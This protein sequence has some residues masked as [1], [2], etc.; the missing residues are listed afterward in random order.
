[1]KIGMTSVYVK[2]PVKAYRFYTD[3]LGFTKKVFV[4]EAGLAIVVSS[5]DRSGTSLLLEP[6]DNPIARAYQEALFKNGIPVI[7]FTAP[8]LEQ[9]YE[10]LQEANVIFRQKPVKTEYGV[11]ALFEDG[12]GNIIQLFQA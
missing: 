3:V 12:F 9:E 4:P 6:N 7:V 10:R 11:E 8:N 1:M 2:D 5:E